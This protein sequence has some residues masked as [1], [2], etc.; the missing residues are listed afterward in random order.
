V[1]HTASLV[2][3]QFSCCGGVVRYLLTTI[4]YTQGERGTGTR[5]P[6]STSRRRHRGQ[7]CEGS[8][9]SATVRPLWLYYASGADRVAFRV[10]CLA[11]Q[12]STHRRCT[13]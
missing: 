5:V 2:R 4:S 7:H 1:R 12:D 10:V 9:R 3:H 8:R 11:P 6:L 13:S